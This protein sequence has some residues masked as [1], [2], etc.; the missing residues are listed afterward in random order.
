V[1]GKKKKNG[2]WGVLTGWLASEDVVEL[3][4]FGDALLPQGIKI[5]FLSQ[6]PRA[7][8]FQMGGET[9]LCPPS[10]QVA[11]LEEKEV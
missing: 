2:S 10:F 3:Q 6:V 9:F 8:S 4:V 7:F 5:S 11:V 1:S